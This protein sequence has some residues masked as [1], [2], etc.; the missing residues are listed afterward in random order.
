MTFETGIES[1]QENRTLAMVACV[2]GIFTPFLGPLI[3]WLIK[4]DQSRFVAFHALQTVLFN[5]A[6]IVASAIASALCT[7]LIGFVLLPI[8]GIVHIIFL[9]LAGM[10]AYRGEW[11]GIPVIGKYAR[12]AAGG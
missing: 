8:V 3:V 5:V 11:Y 10:A 12:Q 9:I 1:N 6:T 2:L 7:V 4:K